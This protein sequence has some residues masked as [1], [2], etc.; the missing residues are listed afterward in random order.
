LECIRGDF[1]GRIV[2]LAGAEVDFHTETFDAVDQFVSQYGREY[3]FVIGSVHYAAKG[4]M[5]CPTYYATRSLDDV[6]LPYLDEV[7]AAVDTCWFDAIGHLDL[8][9]R[10][11]PKGRRTY[12]P[13]QYRERFLAIFQTMLRKNVGFEINTSGIRQ[14]PK[15][16]MPGPTLVR[17]FA[18]TGGRR[19]TT[20]TDSHVARTVGSGIGL[21]LQMLKLCGINE[22]LSFRNRLGTAVSVDQLLQPAVD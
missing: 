20:G 22:V 19:I 4:Q 14:A 2:V 13:G 18:D 17:W 9:K 12:E 8:P 10:Y 1:A 7:Q 21:T 3:D 11:L 15:T 16:S 5:I 6:M